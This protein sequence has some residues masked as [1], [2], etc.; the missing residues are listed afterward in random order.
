[1]QTNEIIQ[2]LNNPNALENLYQT[3]QTEFLAWW[4][5]EATEKYPESETLQVWNARITFSNI[6]ASNKSVVQPVHVFFISIIAGTLVKLH[7]FIDTGWYLSRFVPVIV[8]GSLMTYFSFLESH[9]NKNVP[10]LGIL[11]CINVLLLLPDVTSSAS[12]T[13]SLIHMPL[14]LLSLLALTFM[15]D[16]WESDKLRILFVRYLGE[17]LIYTVIILLGGIVLT[18]LT[19]ALFSLIHIDMTNW[20]LNNVVVFGLVASPIVA[21]YL[22]D[23]VLGR[24]SRLAT[25]IANIFSP[26]VLVTVCVY[27]LA[28][29]VQGKSPYVDRDFLI[30]INGLLLVVLAITIY[31]LSGKGSISK[32]KTLLLY[33]HKLGHKLWKRHCRRTGSLRR[34]FCDRCP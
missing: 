10:I 1:M 6:P 4:L 27:L 19:L 32:R 23:V 30:T 20:Y 8:I 24:E 22:Y 34:F 26:L 25:I 15:G 21:T 18:F 13:M 5:A 29:I 33:R 14:V 16:D 31:S 9:K 3:K 7:T 2:A 12:I 11:I 28:I 17:V